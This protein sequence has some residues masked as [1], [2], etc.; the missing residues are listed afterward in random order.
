MCFANVDIKL[1]DELARPLKYTATNR[2]LWNDKC[3]YIDPD[4]C[5]DLNPSNLN[6][7]ILQLNIRGLLSHQ[8]ELSQ[9]LQD[10][11]IKNSKIDFV[12]LCE[13]H[14]TRFT[15]NLVNI[16]GYILINNNR[17]TKKGGGTAVLVKEGIP[18]TT[19]SDIAQF[20]EQ[21]LESSYIEITVKNG[22][23]FIIG[24]LY[25]APNTNP[26][27]L[28]EHISEVNSKRKSE[29][30]TKELI[31]GMDHNMDLLKSEA[32]TQTSKFLET[33]HDE[34]L[35]PAITRP[36]R[37][38]Q[39]SAT[40][41]DN[42]FLSEILYRQFDSALLIRDISDH[43]PLLVLIKQTKLMDKTPIEFKSRKLN[44][45]KITR[46]KNILFNTDWNVHLSNMD[47]NT[48]FNIFCDH[49]NA[50]METVAP[51]VVVKITG[52][53]RFVEPWMTTGLE[54]TIMKNKKLYH[55]TL[56]VTS[57]PKDLDH[58]KN[59]RNMLNRLKRKA[60]KDYYEDRAKQYKDNTKQL[61]QLLN[62]SIGKCKHKGSII[63]YITV[64]GVR[65][66]TPKKIA[67]NFGKFY[68]TVGE[69]LSATIPVGKKNIDHYLSQIPHNGKSVVMRQTNQTEIENLIKALPN[70]MSSGHNEINNVMLKSLCSA[71]SYPL[72][73][74]FNQSIATGVFPDKMKIAEVIPLY[75][76][77]QRD[78]MINYRPISLLMTISKLLEKVIYSCIYKFLEKNNILFESQY[79]FRT[80]RSCEQAILELTS[81][82]LHAHNKNLHSMGVFLDLSKAFDT[83]NHEV[84][85]KKLNCFGVCGIV[86][87]WFKS[88]LEGRTLIAKINTCK[89]ITTK[90][91]PF[92][93][94][95]GT[96]QGSCLGP[97]LFI[98]FSNDMHLLPIYGHLIL[99]ADDT[100]LI[101]H[102]RNPRFLD[103]ATQHDMA[104]LH[105]WFKANQLSLNLSKS[106]L[107]KFWPG[108][109]KYNIV[110]EGNTIPQVRTTKFLGITIDDEL[111]WRSHINNLYSKIQANKRMLMLAR[112]LIS[113]ENM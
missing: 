39:T 16:P 57:M 4:N 45:D 13:T 110:L 111:N 40:L 83:L 101:N 87:D 86:N 18:F 96:A 27:R 47:C 64:D 67:E 104:I 91:T 1:Y 50:V 102:H 9:L 66:Y 34:N 69:N 46:I 48:N 36:S 28:I 106:S 97:L 89:E 78:L 10:L 103:Y 14:L 85:L 49:L 38:T 62:Q 60:M 107:M 12:L 3:D 75:K 77:K 33:L 100:T 79:G 95:Y 24:S 25:R 29:S 51:L 37:I 15:S 22:K 23:H 92:H 108:D 42:V 43:L 11:E 113:K 35:F 90:S 59:H 54:S 21:E 2:A 41:I 6:F 70:K 31:L 61:W 53:R 17:H 88:Y 44:K 105:D 82:L 94:T 55:Q 74:I 20:Y 68:S 30:G 84:L 56:R 109:T 73:L 112:N 72:Q 76:G 26:S 63:P 99:F 5:T 65:T 8:K 7:G 80:K 93:I 52:K 71:I 19:R 58:Y 98:M 81:H 32:H